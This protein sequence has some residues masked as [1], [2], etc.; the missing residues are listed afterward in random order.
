MIGFV[1]AQAVELYPRI[2][3]GGIAYFLGTS[4]L[5]SL[6]L[7]VLLSKGVSVESKSDALVTSDAELMNGRLAVL[8]LVAFAFTEYVKGGTLV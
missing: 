2:S 7:L 3:D 8:G 1:A 4:V 6:A 5:L